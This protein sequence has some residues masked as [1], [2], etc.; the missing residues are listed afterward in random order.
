MGK[1]ECVCRV[2]E[3]LP[4]S[5]P[6][7]DTHLSVGNGF[8]GRRNIGHRQPRHRRQDIGVH[9]EHPKKRAES[10]R[11]NLEHRRDSRDTAHGSSLGNRRA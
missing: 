5:L 2:P 1:S 6:S 10:H 7:P 3:Y 4:Q 9:V 8:F 11:D